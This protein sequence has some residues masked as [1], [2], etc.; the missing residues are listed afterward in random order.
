MDD[1]KGLRL[2]FA[3]PPIRDLVQGLGATPVGV[4]PTEIA[5]QLQ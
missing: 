5:E 4:P 1:F 2:R 3:S